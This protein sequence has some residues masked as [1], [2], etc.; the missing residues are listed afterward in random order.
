VTDSDTE[1]SFSQPAASNAELEDTTFTDAGK[2]G[3]WTRPTLL[4]RADE[5]IE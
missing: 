5:A 4:A 1:V 3:L 2:L